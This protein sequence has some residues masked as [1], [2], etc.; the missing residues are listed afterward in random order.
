MLSHLSLTH[1]ELLKCIVERLSDR[2]EYEKFE[3]LNSFVLADHKVLWVHIW[4]ELTLEKPMQDTS[5]GRELV[6]EA[7]L[8]SFQHKELH[9]LGTCCKASVGVIMGGCVVGYRV[10]AVIFTLTS[11]HQVPVIFFLLWLFLYGN[12]SLGACIVQHVFQVIK[13][14]KLLLILLWLILS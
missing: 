12:N 11:F 7:D 4:V 14:I 6:F 13:I 9:L 3:L 8:K 5:K 1:D 2:L 10:L